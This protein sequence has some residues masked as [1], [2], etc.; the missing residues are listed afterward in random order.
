[1]KKYGMLLGLCVTAG[2]TYLGY[3]EARSLLRFGV[4]LYG[5]AFLLA[6]ANDEAYATI[7]KSAWTQGMAWLWCVAIG[8]SV[9]AGCWLTAMMMTVVAVTERSV[10]VTEHAKE[11]AH[12]K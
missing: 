4:W 9:M 12:G 1:M 2:A 7:A 3:E 6:L 5:P 10:I 8:L 11:V